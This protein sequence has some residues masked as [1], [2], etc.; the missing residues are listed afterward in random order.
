M[1]P[2]DAKELMRSGLDEMRKIIRERE[3]LTAQLAADAWNWQR[4]N[5]RL[6]PNPHSEIRTCRT[7]PSIATSTGS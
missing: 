7:P 1:T 2:F 4:P 5:E 3:P 6:A